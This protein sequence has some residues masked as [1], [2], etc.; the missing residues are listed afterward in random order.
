MLH[1][2]SDM[3]HVVDVMA[4]KSKQLHSLKYGGFTKSPERDRH[5]D[6]L[7]ADIQQLAMQIAHD[8]S[9]YVRPGDSESEK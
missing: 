5:I 8:T 6:E 9:P 7:I 1:K 2:I 3:I 4:K